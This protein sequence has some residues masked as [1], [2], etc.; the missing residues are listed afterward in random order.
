MPK[1]EANATKMKVSKEYLEDQKSI[2]NVKREFVDKPSN[3]HRHER[4][5]HPY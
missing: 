5:Y 1:A 4:K 2:K 3:S